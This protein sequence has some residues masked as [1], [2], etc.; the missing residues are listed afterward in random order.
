MRATAILLV[1]FWHSYDA[2]TYLAPGFHAPFFLDGVDLFFVLSGYLIGGILL[3]Q[4]RKPQLT[5]GQRLRGFWSRRFFRTLPNY[6][7]FLLVNIVITFC[8]IGPG[9]L[10]HNTVAY[11]AFLQNVWKPLDLFFWEAWS[12]VVEVWFYILFPVL[13]FTLIGKVR[14]QVRTAF[15]LVSACFI[16]APLLMR[17][18]MA[19]GIVDIPASELTVRKLVTTRVDTVVY[20]VVAALMHA[21][22]GTLWHRLRWPLFIVGLVGLCVVPTFYGE[23]HLYYSLTWYYSLNA[24]TM[25]LLLPLLSTWRKEPK[26]GGVVT[27]LSQVSYALFLVHMPLRALL[28]PYYDPSAGFGWLQL[29]GYWIVATMLAWLIQRYYERPMMDLRE[30]VR[31]P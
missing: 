14:M 4:L 30:R 26:G 11:F 21:W 9:I 29:T 25:A 5:M 13:V 18:H 8:G 23:T 6:Y 16:I 31:Q 17:L 24:L 22:Y 27:W 10:N 20:G 12:L 15:M 2:I 7:L 28:E 3:A 19:P 1:V